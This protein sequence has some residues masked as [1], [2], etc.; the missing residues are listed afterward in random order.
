SAVGNCTRLH[1]Q[2][3]G[4]SSLVRIVSTPGRASA[5]AAERGEI[6]GGCLTHCINHRVIHYK[7]IDLTLEWSDF[8]E[9]VDGSWYALVHHPL[10]IKTS[11]VI[12]YLDRSHDAS[13]FAVPNGLGEIDLLT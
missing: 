6:G 9:D 1:R 7:L 11:C 12:R 13:D 3:G 2:A 10:A 5:T 8:L 4:P